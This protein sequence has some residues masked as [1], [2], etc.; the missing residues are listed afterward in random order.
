MARS[1]NRTKRRQETTARIIEA[2]ERLFADR[3][4][5]QTTMQDVVEEAG[6]SIG[7]L[8]FYFQNKDEL[9]QAVVDGVVREGHRVGDELAVKVAPGPARLAIATFASVYVLLAPGSRALA[10]FTQ[11]GGVAGEQIATRNAD[12]IHRY[13]CENV[14]EL[15]PDVC[16]YAS[17]IWTGAARGAIQAHVQHGTLSTL[18]LATFLTR[19]NLRGIGVAEDQIDE[20]IDMAVR[21]VNV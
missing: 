16:N 12:R 13:L 15:D 3:G 10:I 19:W 17:R 7:N 8:Y 9:L 2:A 21:M 6:T 1:G 5:D 11:T 4:F 18:Q 14:P 20:A